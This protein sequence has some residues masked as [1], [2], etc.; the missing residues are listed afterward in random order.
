MFVSRPKKVVGTSA[1][2]TYELINDMELAQILLNMPYEKEVRF[3][4]D[5]MRALDF[6]EV[7]ADVHYIKKTRAFGEDMIL[8][9]VLDGR[10]IKMAKINDLKP[11]FRQEETIFD[12]TRF[13]TPYL[14]EH[15]VRKVTVIKRRKTSGRK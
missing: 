12:L 4:I 6:W 14:N 9:G 13:I 5:D 8:A 7:P 1:V 11:V 3:Y 15:G 10:G 2:M